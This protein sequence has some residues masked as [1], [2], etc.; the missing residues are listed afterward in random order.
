MMFEA[1]VVT[2]ADQEVCNGYTEDM[3]HRLMALAIM[4]NLQDRPAI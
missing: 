4:S 3:V 1:L 2:S